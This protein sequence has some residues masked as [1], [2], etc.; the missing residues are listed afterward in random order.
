MLWEIGD[1]GRLIEVIDEDLFLGMEGGM[2]LLLF[3]LD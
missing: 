3:D 1:D 2:I